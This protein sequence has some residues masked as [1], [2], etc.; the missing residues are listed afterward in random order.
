[1]Q[2]LTLRI[3]HCVE[4]WRGQGSRGVRQGFFRQLSAV[5]YERRCKKDEDEIFR[6]SLCCIPDRLRDICADGLRMP[7]KCGNSLIVAYDIPRSVY[8]PHVQ[9]FGAD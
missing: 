6:E 9:T 4:S 5:V 2:R 8:T 1:M 3:G 7:I